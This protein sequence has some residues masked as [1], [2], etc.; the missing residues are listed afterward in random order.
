VQS[1]SASLRFTALWPILFAAHALYHS[2]RARNLK[3]P[4]H[5]ALSKIHL[6]RELAA[7]LILYDLRAAPT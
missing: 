1:F 5:R 4:A 7:D 2:F 3:L 6:A